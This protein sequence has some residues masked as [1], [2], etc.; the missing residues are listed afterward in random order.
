MDH[1]T[2]L[3]ESPRPARDLRQHVAGMARDINRIGELQVQLLAAD[4]GRARAKM[5]AGLGCW[6]GA[7]GFVLALLPVAVGGFGLWLSDVTRLSPAGGLLC[8]AAAAVV[9]AAMLL[10]IGW[11]QFRKQRE[12][13]G[14]S[15]AELRK[16]MAAV[17]EALLDAAAGPTETSTPR[18]NET[19]S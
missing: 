14:T 11:W 1:Q 12:L 9:I 6:A 4:L 8:A 2:T 16:N 19:Y 15:L 18:A 7:V 3:G 13:W 10:L 5:L 17:R